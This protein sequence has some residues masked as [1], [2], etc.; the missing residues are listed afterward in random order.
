MKVLITGASSGMGRDMARYLASSGHELFLVARRKE[1]LE[2]LKKELTNVKVTIISLDLSKK[3]NCFKLYEK[4]KNENID[5]LINNA[6][7]LLHVEALLVFIAP[8]L[9]QLFKSVVPQ[10]LHL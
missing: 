2:A 9:G 4:L 3:E 10:F 7:H 1:R 5:F 6:P 8:Q